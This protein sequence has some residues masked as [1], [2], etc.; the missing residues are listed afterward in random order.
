MNFELK[1]AELSDIPKL[2]NY[3]L[4]SIFAYAPNLPKE[5]VLKINNYVKN[6]I[7]QNL[8]SIQVICVN[9]KV[10]GC[11]ILENIDDGILLDEIYLEQ[12]YR[13]QKIGTKIINQ[14]LENNDIV[15]LWVY[16]LNTKA[17]SLYQRLGFNII[18]ETEERYYMKI[19]NNLSFM[20]LNG[21]DIG[22][23]KIELDKSDLRITDQS[24][25][26]CLQVCVFY[27]WN[28]IN[29]IRNNQKEEIDFNEYC[30][31]LNNEPAL[32][33]PTKNFVEKINADLICFYLEFKD[34]SN[35]T[36][37]MN[38]RGY[39]DIKLKSLIVKAYIDYKDIV[40]INKRSNKEFYIFKQ[41][42]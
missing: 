2:I 31:S 30:L 29:K 42:C 7:R 1:E 39:F 11:V 4:K 6:N 34:L 14:I 5:E 17:L 28:D 13:N 27:N 40:D 33:W 22:I 25:K 38:K 12:A 37:Y 3:K 20:I 26:Y 23:S 36:H 8:E 18:E 15:Y 41:K 35:T 10:I 21:I 16:K 32:I 9:K 19:R 24:G